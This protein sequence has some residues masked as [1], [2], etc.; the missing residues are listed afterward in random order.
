MLHGEAPGCP[1]TMTDR[2]LLPYLGRVARE[3]RETAGLTREQVAVL[4][5]TKRG[6]PVASTTILRFEHAQTWPQNPDA[7]IAAYS[8]ATGVA[9]CELWERALREW[10]RLNGN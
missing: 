9:T 8:D 5:I 3:A 7:T 4:V 2:Q 1:L 10:C 6:R